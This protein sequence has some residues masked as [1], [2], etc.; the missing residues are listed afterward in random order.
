MRLISVG[1]THRAAQVAL[2][3]GGL[4]GEDVAQVRMGTLD[5]AIPQELEAL[6]GAALGLHLWHFFLLRVVKS[7]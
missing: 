1:E 2:L 3:L 6:F 4:L 5:L 7:A